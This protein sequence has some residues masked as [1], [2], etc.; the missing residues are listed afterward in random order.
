[1][2]SKLDSS[3]LNRMKDCRLDTHR[4]LRQNYRGNTDARAYKNS[5]YLNDAISKRAVM[6]M[7]LLPP[8]PML[9]LLLLTAI[10]CVVC[11]VFTE[12][13]V[14]LLIFPFSFSICTNIHLHS[15]STDVE[16]KVHACVCTRSCLYVWM[17]NRYIEN[18]KANRLGLIS[19]ICIYPLK[20][21]F[22]S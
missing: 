10:V 9:L 3:E 17:R 5:I 14:C 12:L 1:M 18:D 22:E 8:L 6:P 13:W 16:W 7:L 20:M 15:L 2:P 11:F 21:S 4:I 19:F